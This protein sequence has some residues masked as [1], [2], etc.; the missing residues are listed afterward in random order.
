VKAPNRPGSASGSVSFWNARR[1][2]L[3]PGCRNEDSASRFSVQNRLERCV[4]VIVSSADTS[5][6][7]R[8]GGIGPCRSDM[9]TVPPL[10]TNA[11]TFGIAS[12]RC[13]SSRC[14]HTAVSM[15]KSNS[16]LRARKAA[17]SGRLSSSHSIIGDRCRSIAPRRS[18]S[19]GS[20]ATTECPRAASPAASR[21][22]P[23]PISRARHGAAGSVAGWT[24]EHLQKRCSHRA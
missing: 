16:S 17:K 7:R 5:N 24:H 23:E 12:S 10:R 14:I 1:V 18:S 19:V 8:P 20:T 21:P 22:V 3:T 4:N 11:K 6:M 15:T 13:A 9:I 2:Q